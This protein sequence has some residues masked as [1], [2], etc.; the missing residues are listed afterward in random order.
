MIVYMIRVKTHN[1]LI[2][3]LKV[4][5]SYGLQWQLNNLILVGKELIKEFI[6]WLTPNF[7][8]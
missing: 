4:P 7:D 1:E 3:N 8:F 5:I 2:Q 6:I